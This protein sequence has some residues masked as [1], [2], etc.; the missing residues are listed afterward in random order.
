MRYL[1]KDTIF[2]WLDPRTKI[3]LSLACACLIVILDKPM[4]L[5]VLFIT[6]LFGFILLK[7][8]FSYVKLATYLMAI[9][10][11]ATIISQGLFYY[12]EPKTP[13]VTILPAE[14][15]L[16][17]RITGGIYLYKEGLI[18]GAVQSMRLFS[19]MLLGMIIVMTTYPSELILGLN[20]LGVS[21]RVGFM[22]TVSIRFL[23]A[24]VEEAKRI[25]IAQRLRGLRLKG[26]SGAF[27]GF[28]FLLLPLIIDSLR[29]A[30]RI[31]LAA[32]VRAFSGK[33]TSVKSLKFSLLDWVTFVITSLI[34]ILAIKY[35]FNL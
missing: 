18:Y 28:C 25:L 13:L 10:F 12:F 5:L 21:E 20:R 24:L 11:V 19:A 27:K 8:P 6:I 17:G 2:H 29:S 32:E 15:G 1:D 9:A 30:R 22:L 7:P 26:I 3:F 34:I 31:A 14:F 16:L 33:R 23:P 4:S 35:R